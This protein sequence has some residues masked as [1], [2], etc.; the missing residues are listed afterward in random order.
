MCRERGFNG[1]QGVVIPSTNAPDLML[2]RDVVTARENGD[3]AVYAVNDIYDAAA[4]MMGATV[5]PRGEDGS[6]PSATLLAAAEDRA[7]SYK[8]R[9]EST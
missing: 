7:R 9:P 3:F 8:L 5:S 2:H 4:I 6:Y 1:E